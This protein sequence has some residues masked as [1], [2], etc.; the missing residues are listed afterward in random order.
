MPHQTNEP[1]RKTLHIAIG[2]GAL[3][4]RFL[5]WPWVAAVCAF[6][7]FSNWFVLHRLVGVRVSR[8]ERGWDA[9]TVLYPAMVLLL[10]LVFREETV[11]IGV[12]WAALAF[13]DGF[14]GLIGKSVGGPRL[15]WNRE[16]SW[17]GFAAF[18]AF[19]FV[20][21]IFIARWLMPPRPFLSLEVIVGAAVLVAAIVESLP[22][23]IDDNVT[24]PL[25]AGAVAWALMHMHTLPVVIQHGAMPW[26][27][28]NGVL[29]IV[30][31]LARSVDVS[32][33]IAGFI[34]GAILI[35]FGGWPLY[36]VL[37]AFFIIGTATTKLGYRVKAA[38]GLAQEKGGR[39]GFSHAF[40]NVGMAAILAICASAALP[41]FAIVWW[42]AAAAALAT[43]AADTTASEVGQLLGRRTFLP[44]T[45]RP[46]PVGTEGAISLEGTVAGIAAAAIVATIAVRARTGLFDFTWI[47]I[48]IL[49]AFLGSYLESIAGSWNRK[50]E[51]P[52]PNGVLNFI[53]TM[54]GAGLVLAFVPRMV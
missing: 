38:R 30:G 12:G 9:G 20:G 23:N 18:L 45:F 11:P 50:Q 26:L 53:N 49:A 43:A 46:V 24:V 4:L 35:L 17:S 44:L 8:H 33:A 34:L 25:S 41:H 39:R 52:V 7:V 54:I 2:F 29:A 1:L 27:I 21:A 6:A 36:V 32:G 31:Y 37:L 13:G 5:P 51:K 40:S 48:L 22:T 16:K 3:L 47:A 28:A 19:G 42:M 10:V 15:P 14:A